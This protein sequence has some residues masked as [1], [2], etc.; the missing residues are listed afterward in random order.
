MQQR[1]FRYPDIDLVMN[2]GTQ[3]DEASV[4][5]SDQDAA[6]EIALR[7]HEIQVLE[8]LRGSMVVIREGTVV[9]CY[10]GRDRQLKK[11]LRRGR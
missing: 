4:L 1:A 6:R 7:K 2:C 8:R 11:A 5:L 3:F 9:T 10:H